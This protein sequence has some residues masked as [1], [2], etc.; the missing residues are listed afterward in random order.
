MNT[1]RERDREREREKEL[2]KRF[3]FKN[4]IYRLVHESSYFV[5]FRKAETCFDRDKIMKWQN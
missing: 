3:F 4:E 1:L 5:L 2:S